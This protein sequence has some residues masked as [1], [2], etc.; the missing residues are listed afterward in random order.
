MATF[1]NFVWD[2]ILKDVAALCDRGEIKLY[3]E[4]GVQLATLRLPPKA[5]E[6]QVDGTFVAKVV[7]DEERAA[8]SG[9]ATQ[10]R[11]FGRNQELILAG[12]VGERGD[13]QA[14]DAYIEAGGRVSISNF[15]LSPGR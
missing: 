6:R 12:T 13:L 10:F 1:S 7:E 15:I 3:A 9:M 4:N 2:R 5:F 11:V 8:I 14:T